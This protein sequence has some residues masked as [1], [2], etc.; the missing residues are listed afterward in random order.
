M[1]LTRMPV[2]F[3]LVSDTCSLKMTVSPKPVVTVVFGG[4]EYPLLTCVTWLSSKMA[5]PNVVVAE[6][7]LPSTLHSLWALPTT[8]TSTR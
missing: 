3:P 4:G 7:P 8:I 5:D 2:V 6:T 1:A